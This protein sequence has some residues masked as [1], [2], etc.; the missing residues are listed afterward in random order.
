MKFPFNTVDN[1]IYI[2][3]KCG[4]GIKEE[5]SEGSD[6]EMSAIMAAT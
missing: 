1:K 2:T 6:E 3:Y 5:K 4:H